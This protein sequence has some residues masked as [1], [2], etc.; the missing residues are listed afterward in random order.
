MANKACCAQG[1][2]YLEIRYLGPAEVEFDARLA[3]NRRVMDTTSTAEST[4]CY[5]SVIM[6]RAT[7]ASRW[8]GETWT[9]RGVVCD[10][11]APGAPERVIVER[12][13]LTQILFP[14]CR[15]ALTPKEA[16]GYLLN[17]SSPEPKIFVMWRLHENLARPEHLTV[18]YQEGARWMDSEENVDGV[19]LPNELR[20][21]IAQY[22][23]D[24]YKPEPKKPKRYASSKDKGRMGNY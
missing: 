9:A 18:S 7:V 14:G 13:G 1:K 6:E 16:E 4:A 2:H 19:P 11:S 10:G 24:N 20:P 17:L 15:I 22:A 3:Q 5:V 8:G 21:W 12:E 23:A